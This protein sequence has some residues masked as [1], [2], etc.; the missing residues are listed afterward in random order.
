MELLWNFIEGPPLGIH[1]RLRVRPP[2]Q[3][4]DEPLGRLGHHLL[5]ETDTPT[6]SLG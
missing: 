2:L 4:A 3:K 5:L 1:C 6:L